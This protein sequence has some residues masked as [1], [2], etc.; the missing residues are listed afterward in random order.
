MAMLFATTSAIFV[1]SNNVSIIP[2]FD[3]ASKVYAQTLSDEGKDYEDANKT[4][5]AKKNTAD[6]L[7]EEEK[8]DKNDDLL[9]LR[10][11]RQTQLEEYEVA[12]PN[13]SNTI[14]GVIYSPYQFEPVSIGG[15]VF[16]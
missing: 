16:H 1:D 5:E 11:D 2:G 13:F 10:D 12:S 7:A 4:A 9:R 14:E 15:N 6:Q 3:N 8:Y